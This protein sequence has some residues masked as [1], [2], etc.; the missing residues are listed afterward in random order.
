MEDME[1]HMGI[2]TGTRM[3]YD[4]A[5]LLQNWLSPS[6]PVG[7]YAYSHGLEYAV[8]ANFVKDRDSCR[9][10]IS[11]LI[12]LGSWRNDAIIAG[13]AWQTAQEK[14][15]AGLSALT[16]LARALSPS[17]ERHLESVQQGTAFV[18]AVRQ[19]WPQ[20]DLAALL[21]P[22]VDDIPYAVAIGI[23]AAVHG[24][25]R[26]AML[27]AFGMGFAQALV[28]AALRLSVIGHT[29]GQKILAALTPLITQTADELKDA[30]LDD[31]GGA[32]FFSDLASLQ[33]E[34]QYTRFF[35]S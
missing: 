12:T 14:N 10:W 25:A 28:S 16:E 32:S 30:T 18:E 26:A 33:H 6:F 27:S 17:R 5:L 24:I 8:H 1:Q 23:C 2:I 15:G 34:T 21:P 3:R 7:A 29:D 35:R 9:E 20:A 11:D 4:A 22:D 19:S 31:L 13:V